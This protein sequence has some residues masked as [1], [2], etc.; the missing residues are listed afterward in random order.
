MAGQKTPKRWE[1]AIACLMSEPTIAAAAAK[2]NMPSRTLKYWLANPQFQTLFREARRQ[3]V[4][5]AVTR[6]QQT[7]GEAVDAL[8]RLLTCGHAQ[9]EARVA[10]TIL[11]QALRG[12]E[13]GDLVQQVEELRAE[14]EGLKHGAGGAAATSQEN[15]GG[16]GEAFGPGD[17][18]AG[19]T[20]G[21]PVED[22]ERGGDGA[23]PVAKESPEITLSEDVTPLFETGRQVSDSSRPGSP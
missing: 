20:A 13:L 3:V 7:T 6:V 1:I 22:S 4:E 19:A 16:T 14:L 23:R 2:A 21:G 15:A 18:A 17:A 11:E 9:T 5:Q 8:K 12:V 10:T